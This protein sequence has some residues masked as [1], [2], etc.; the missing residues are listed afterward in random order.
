M[1]PAAPHRGLVSLMRKKQPT[2]ARSGTQ[3]RR[4]RPAQLEAE[5]RAAGGAL[6]VRWV[7]A[8]DPEQ[9]S[10]LND[11]S[12]VPPA[13]LAAQGAMVLAETR[14]GVTALHGGA[15]RAEQGP[16]DAQLT[17]S[18]GIPITNGTVTRFADLQWLDDESINALL[19][20]AEQ[21][22]MQQRR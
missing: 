8:H 15:E 13:V 18:E 6:W 4:P 10:L 7:A 5:D 9:Q 21:W 17:E 12:T 16:G 20:L 2:A 3:E 14:P 22:A 19:K 1:C 11:D